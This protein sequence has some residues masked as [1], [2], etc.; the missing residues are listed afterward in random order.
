M[1]FRD[2]KRVEISS[3]EDYFNPKEGSPL[4]G[5][6]SNSDCSLLA[7]SP[8]KYRDT[9]DGIIDRDEKS[10]YRIGSAFDSLV[11]T[12]VAFYEDYSIVPEDVTTPN[13]DMQKAFYSLL[14][15]GTSEK[16][17]ARM[18]GYQRAPKQGLFDK[19][20]E[21][22]SSHEGKILLPWEDA[23]LIERM[24]ERI[25]RH[26]LIPN[27]I[28]AS[29]KQAVFVG[30]HED[31]G[32]KVKCM[33]DLLWEYKEGSTVTVDLKSTAA[34]NRRAFRQDFYK[35]GYDK[36]AALY[37]Q[38]AGAETAAIIAVSKVSSW[39]QAV[40]LYDYLEE[41]EKKAEYLLE[42]MAWHMETNTWDHSYECFC[43]DGWE[44][45]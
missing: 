42:A 10:G 40:P 35:Y 11:L 39:H 33:I 7:E 2:V 37:S 27:I 13:T 24:L 45:L 4:E 12:P 30:I 1:N 15:E 17:A 26:P 38:V 16:E 3:P 19:L 44:A 31:T 22:G 32:L 36:Q 29:E 20:L 25:L 9:K 18:A 8:R 34:T 14:A 28:T 5:A 43:G 21:F 6:V 41:G 23:R